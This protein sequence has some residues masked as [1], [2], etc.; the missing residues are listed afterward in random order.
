VLGRRNTVSSP[1]PGTHS[2]GDRDENSGLLQSENLQS[3]GL[4]TV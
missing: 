4:C 1:D 2:A 3:S